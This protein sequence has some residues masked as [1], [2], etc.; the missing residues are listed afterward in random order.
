MMQF[1]SHVCRL[2]MVVSNLAIF[3]IKDSYKKSLSGFSSQEVCQ[4]YVGMSASFLS[5]PAIFSS[6]VDASFDE[7]SHIVSWPYILFTNLVLIR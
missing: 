7:I 1:S 3:I 5:H 4:I 6:P 2:T